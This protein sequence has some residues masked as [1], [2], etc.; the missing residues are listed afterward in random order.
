MFHRG[1]GKLTA[2]TNCLCTCHTHVIR[3]VGGSSEELHGIMHISGLSVNGSIAVTI[4][5][6]RVTLERTQR[7]LEVLSYGDAQGP[8][9]T[10]TH[11]VVLSQPTPKCTDMTVT[12]GSRRA[13]KRAQDS[14]SQES[15]AHLLLTAHDCGQSLHL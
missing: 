7:P 12:L 4:F 11:P 5:S 6:V 3:V 14:W 1:W 13:L 8:S 10:S 15:N 2:H 9:L